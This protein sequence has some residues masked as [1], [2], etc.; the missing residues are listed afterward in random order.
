[1]FFRSLNCDGSSAAGRGPAAT[2]VMKTTWIPAVI[3]F[4]AA[5]S[6]LVAGLCLPAFSQQMSF[7]L[8]QP[9]AME[10]VV[11]VQPVS[12]EPLP[13]APNHRFWDRENRILF[14]AVAASSTADFA[15]TRANLHNGGRE[16]NPVARVFG[17][18]TAGLALNF[19]GETAGVV[20]LS[21]FFHK[22]GHHKL[23]RIV[24]MANIGASGVAVA[25]GLGHR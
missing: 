16:L 12:A 25:Y 19:A 7:A 23:E 6:L 20:G 22:T 9:V 10:P 15:V 17:G 8:R 18:S 13:S 5:A 3:K 2:K 14:A 4:G 1:M 11:A 24:S 21:Y